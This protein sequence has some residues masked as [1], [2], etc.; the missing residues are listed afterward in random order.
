VT[1]QDLDGNGPLPQRWELALV[2]DDDVAPR[3]VVHDLLRVWTAP[4]PDEIEPFIHFVG[5]STVTAISHAR[6]SA[7]EY[8]ARRQ[9]GSLRIGTP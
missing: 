7:E 4:R 1:E 2:D 6:A 3:R 5:A 9:R 8:G